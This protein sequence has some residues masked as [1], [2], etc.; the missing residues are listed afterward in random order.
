MFDTHFLLT[1]YSE[2]ISLMQRRMNRS[3]T[4]PKSTLADPW[5][6]FQCHLILEMTNMEVPRMLDIAFLSSV[7]Q[8]LMWI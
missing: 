2:L 5:G 8:R 6:I 1:K 4:E 7:W 3:T